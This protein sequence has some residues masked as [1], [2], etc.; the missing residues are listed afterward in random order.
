MTLRNNPTFDAIRKRHAARHFS[1]REIPDPV[2]IELL[3]LAN[4]APSGFNLQPWHFVLVKNADL[5]KLLMHVAMDQ[6]QVGEAPMTVVFIADP[7]VWRTTYGR[8]LSLGIDSKRMT[9][10]HAAFNRKMVNLLFR[11]GPLGIYGLGK[12]IA[13][14]LRRLLKPTPNVITSQQEAAHYVR[15][16][17][18]LAAMTFMVAAKSIGLDTSPMEGF[19]EERLK[20]LL[21][22]PSWMTVPVIISIGYP[23][24]DETPPAS[25][26]LPLEEK[27][28]LDL[29]PNRVK[30]GPKRAG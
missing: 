27:L 23:L 9:E 26:R 3:E 1:S 12:K 11:T 15:S 20:K 28:S 17:T 19:D 2:I 21:A 7:R 4:R 22:I 8:V 5:R 18:M 24:D 29:F 14:P 6:P 10:R 16:H 25:V 30:K 13:V